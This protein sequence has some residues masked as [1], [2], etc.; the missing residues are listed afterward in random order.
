MSHP[1][2]LVHLTQDELCSIIIFFLLFDIDS[3]LSKSVDLL[4]KRI[5]R[6]IDY[7]VELILA[8]LILADL[9]PQQ[10][11]HCLFLLLEKLGQ[12][13]E[14]LGADFEWLTWLNYLRYTFR[15]SSIV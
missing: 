12:L 13:I 2:D 6:I 15:S 9:G 1:L 7:V 4:G 10:V 3:Q 5:L 14:E 8:L 11:N